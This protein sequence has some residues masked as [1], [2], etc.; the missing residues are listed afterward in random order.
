MENYLVL[1]AVVELLRG[2]P[3]ERA[4]SEARIADDLRRADLALVR[5]IK[6]LPNLT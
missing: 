5:M 4:I 1:T 6:K 3:D 2:S